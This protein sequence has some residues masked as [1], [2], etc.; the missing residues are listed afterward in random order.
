MDPTNEVVWFHLMMEAEPASGMLCV[1][2]LTDKG[3]CPKICIS[4]INNKN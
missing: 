2:T 1:S 4:L 3:K